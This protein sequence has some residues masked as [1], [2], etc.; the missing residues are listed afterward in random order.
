MLS[1][2]KSY[3][4]CYV[5]QD[6]LILANLSYVTIAC[7]DKGFYLWVLVDCNTH[8]L[9]KHCQGGMGEGGVYERDERGGK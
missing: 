6:L 7:D 4:K 3:K 2:T 1:V 8:L 5:Q 9:N